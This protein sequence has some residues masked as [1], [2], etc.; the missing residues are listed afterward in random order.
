M[1]KCYE[2]GP[3][4]VNHCLSFRSTR[5]KV[6]GWF[7]SSGNK[8]DSSEAFNIYVNGKLST[9]NV[10]NLVGINFFD[11]KILNLHGK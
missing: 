8:F 4:K 10:A 6:R 7:P 2:T 9:K 1:G 11:S 5:E 3:D